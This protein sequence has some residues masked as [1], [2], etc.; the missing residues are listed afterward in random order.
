MLKSREVARELVYGL[1]I[2]FSGCA[3]VAQQR[4]G[5]PPARDPSA[6]T[7]ASNP[8][9]K[10]IAKEDSS[11][12]NPAS[13]N[14]PAVAS[15]TTAKGSEPGSAEAFAHLPENPPARLRAL[16]RLAEERY[17]SFESYIARVHRRETVNDKKKP[18]EVYLFKYRKQP[19][20]VYFKWI[21]TEAQGREVIYVQGQHDNKIQTLLAT[22]DNPLM[23]AGSRMALAPDS[24]LVRSQSRHSITEAGIGNIIDGFG[25]LLD[26]TE[27]GD[28]AQGSVKYLGPIKRPEFE[29][30]LEAAE[31]TIPPGLEAHLPRGGRR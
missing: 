24:I 22:G 26:A 28:T 13:H 4:S 2:L 19:L 6:A 27:K 31:K 23:P 12:V 5:I 25:K 1:F 10:P 9:K 17:E 15:P 11:G 3:E 16:H 18:E 7:P 29:S 20:S 14:V 21:G 30:P 8:L